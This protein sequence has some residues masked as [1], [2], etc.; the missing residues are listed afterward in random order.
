MM[1]GRPL[2]ALERPLFYHDAGHGGLKEKG[3]A[4]RGKMRSTRDESR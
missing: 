1:R 2:G 4:L 3:P